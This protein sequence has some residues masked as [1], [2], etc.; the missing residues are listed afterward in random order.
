MIDALRFLPMSLSLRGLQRA[1]LVLLMALIM[2]QTVGILHRVAHAQQ[3]ATQHQHW[4]SKQGIRRFAGVE[5]FH[6][7]THASAANAP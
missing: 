4:E 5:S 6:A 2:V 1:M 7:A 3:S